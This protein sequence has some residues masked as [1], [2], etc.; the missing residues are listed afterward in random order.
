M[1][2]LSI[3]NSLLILFFCQFI[4]LNGW[5]QQEGVVTVESSQ[6]IKELLAKKRSY[7]KNKKMVKGYKVQLFY[8]SEEGALKIRDDFRSVYPDISSELKFHSPY[9][10]VWVGCY[11]SRLSAD[12][13]LQE[14]KEGFASAIVVPAKVKVSCEN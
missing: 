4:W 7:N 14:I 2:K 8:G 9:W 5:S 11:T 3:R 12:K 13:G 10:K 6:S 1:R